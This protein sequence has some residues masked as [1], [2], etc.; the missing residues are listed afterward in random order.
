ME[1]NQSEKINNWIKI[2]LGIIGTITLGAIGSG[3]WERF[4]SPLTDGTFSYVGQIIGNFSDTF[5]D[6]IYSDVGKG[7][8]MALGKFSVLIYAFYLLMI[9]VSPFLY[10][11]LFGLI[12]SKL[13]NRINPKSKKPKKINF[14]KKLTNEWIG[15]H[16]P[17]QLRLSNLKKIKT[18]TF[19]ILIP[20]CFWMFKFGL[21]KTVKEA[22]GFDVVVYIE[23][24]LDIIAPY[25]DE[26]ELKILKSEFRQIKDYD[27]FMKFN[28]KLENHANRT[29]II[30]P[31]I[32]V[33]EFK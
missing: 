23:S 27:S 11:I 14:F 4:L 28:N 22:Y 2:S 5:K 8:T 33:I 32:S 20:V 7:S 15:E 25:I 31:E 19:I 29:R 24:S 26:K 30:L 18:I 9:L 6:E 3:I 17:L 12:F 21:T 16:L 13:R 1:N 10:L